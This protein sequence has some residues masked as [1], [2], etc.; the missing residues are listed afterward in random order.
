MDPVT[1]SRRLAKLPYAAVRRPFAFFDDRLLARYWNEDA[2]LR[3]GFGRLLGS[4]DRFAGWLLADDTISQCGRDLLG[5]T[6]PTS[7]AREQ[8]AREQAAA[9]AGEDSQ[10]VPAAADA[11]AET[12]QPV[13]AQL[14]RLAA[15]EPAAQPGTPAEP[16][17][18]RT[19]DVTFT[20]PGEV[21]AGNVVLCGDFN[22]WSAGN[23]ALQRGSDGA[24]EVTLPLEPGRSYRYRYL[25]DGERWENAW[26]ADWYEP[27]AFGSTNSVVNVDCPERTLELAA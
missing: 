25:L 17:A 3:S 24:W 7:D 22:D 11:P 10:R 9:P 2:I 19:V 20:L 18:A 13:A 14:A 1:I 27:N 21:G 4:M 12:G 5:R 23:I 6:G 15:R 26:Q 16:A 8:A